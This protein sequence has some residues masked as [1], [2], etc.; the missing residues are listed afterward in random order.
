MTAF[1]VS[2]WPK[3]FDSSKTIHQ[4]AD[5][6]AAMILHA[7]APPDAVI[8]TQRPFPATVATPARMFLRD[9]DPDEASEW[10]FREIERCF[11]DFACTRRS[12]ELWRVGHGSSAARRRIR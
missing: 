1:Q 12:V 3:G 6:R 10:S 11:P 2:E 8:V 5:E 4:A 9:L 7:G